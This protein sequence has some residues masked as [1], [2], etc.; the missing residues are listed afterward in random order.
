M[1]AEHIPPI[2]KVILQIKNHPE[3]FLLPHL[4]DRVYLLPGGLVRRITQYRTSIVGHTLD[5]KQQIAD[6]LVIELGN[7][8][9]EVE[10]PARDCS[11]AFEEYVARASKIE[12][13]DAGIM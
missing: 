6:I 8:C 4:L 1:R 11:G 5:V 3:S 12:I 10:A 13:E 7:L 9:W 2:H